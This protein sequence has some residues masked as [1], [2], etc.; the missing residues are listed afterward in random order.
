MSPSPLF[1]VILAC[2]SRFELL[3][4]ACSRDDDAGPSE[5]RSNDRKQGF[6]PFC[7]LLS[8]SFLRDKCRKMRVKFQSISGFALADC[9]TPMSSG[10]GSQHSYTALP[11]L[12]TVATRCTFSAD[13]T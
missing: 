6:K 9:A 7:A 13:P 1:A 2:E 8:A 12:F 5:K 10:S 4:L 11:G 3:I